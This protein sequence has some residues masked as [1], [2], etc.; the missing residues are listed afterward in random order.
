MHLQCSDKAKKN[1]ALRNPSQKLGVAGI[2][3]FVI[4]KHERN[5]C[6]CGATPH[7]MS[8]MVPNK[9]NDKTIF[10]QNTTLFY[11]ILKL[12]YF[13]FKTQRL[14]YSCYSR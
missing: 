5:L 14:R 7:T 11:S 4:V 13:L 10:E 12:F 3:F 2:A 1:I 8:K 6:L 9:Q